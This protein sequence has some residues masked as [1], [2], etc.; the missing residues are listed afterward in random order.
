MFIVYQYGSATFQNINIL[1]GFVEN[2]LLI[3][4]ERRVSHRMIPWESES[5]LWLSCGHILVEIFQSLYYLLF[6]T[7]SSPNLLNTWFLVPKLVMQCLLPLLHF[8]C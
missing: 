4:V 5:T 3:L 7:S 8:L 2:N 1:L 6:L